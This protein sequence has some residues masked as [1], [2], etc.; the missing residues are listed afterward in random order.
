[1]SPSGTIKGG[2]KREFQMPGEGDWALLV[3]R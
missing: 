2:E 3:V 1:L